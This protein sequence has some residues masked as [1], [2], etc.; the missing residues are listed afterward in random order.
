M[1]P[2]REEERTRRSWIYRINTNQQ[3]ATMKCF[4]FLSTIL[5]VVFASDEDLMS[6]DGMPD[7]PGLPE[8][9]KVPTVAPP[10][11]DVYSAKICL[12][13]KIMKY[14]E[15][16][17]EGLTLVMRSKCNKTCFECAPAPCVDVK[18]TTYNC[19]GAEKAGFCK[20]K[21]FEKA[22]ELY[23]PKTCGFC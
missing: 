8:L 2:F 5:G 19:A 15:G 1:G 17:S 3:I 10:C 6:I 9:P 18:P 7:L 16:K 20:Y 11:A 14:C 23:C 22:L 21:K 12:I 13:Y 4:L